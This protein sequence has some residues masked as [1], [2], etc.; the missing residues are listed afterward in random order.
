MNKFLSVVAKWIYMLVKL[1]ADLVEM[2]NNSMIFKDN[3]SSLTM[4]LLHHHLRSLA[5]LVNYF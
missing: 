2:S 1:S 4:S 3:F 5:V